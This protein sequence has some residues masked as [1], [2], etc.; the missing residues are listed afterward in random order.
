MQFNV[1]P[2]E[3]RSKPQKKKAY[4]IAF[5]QYQQL[6]EELQATSDA[7]IKNLIFRRLMNLLN[8]M[9]FLNQQALPL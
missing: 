4:D 2:K 8:V 1:V 3:H 5:E 9:Q 6:K 7:K